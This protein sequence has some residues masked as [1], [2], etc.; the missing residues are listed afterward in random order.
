MSTLPSEL[1]D[2]SPLLI[3]SGEQNHV[4]GCFRFENSYSMR[5]D[6]TDVLRKAWTK[7]FRGRK[8]IDIWQERLASVR[9]NLKGWDRNV[10]GEYKKKGNKLHT[11]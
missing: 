11:S 9:K 5:P 10:K 7:S 2:H 3:K 6:F 1:S 8:M 4:P